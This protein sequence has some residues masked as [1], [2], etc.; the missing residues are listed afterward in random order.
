MHTEEIIKRTA[1]A[2]LKAALPIF[3]RMLKEAAETAAAAATKTAA[4][5]GAKSAIDTIEKE[6]QKA[7]REWHDRRLRNT[8][9]LLQNYRR[10]MEHY[11]NAV[12]DAATLEE[13]DYTAAEIFELMSQYVYD[14]DLYVESIKKSAARTHI[15]MEHLNKMLGVYEAYC[16]KA[17]REDYKRHWRVI[18]ALYLDE[19]PT[20]VVKL[21]MT[22]YV[23]ERTIYRDIDAA[24]EELSALLFG[25]DGIKR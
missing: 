6:R 15:I 12:Y 23:G 24:C 18:K 1:E 21:A 17:Q 8:K 20:T 4:R 2:T 7:A 14:N 10:L 3:E 16:E 13:E 19:T 25:I 5:T 9:L 22:E 11:E